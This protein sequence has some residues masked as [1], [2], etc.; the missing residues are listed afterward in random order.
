LIV[1][2]IS[3]VHS[4]LAALEAVLDDAGYWDAS[5]CAGDVV[6]YGPKPQECIDRIAFKGFNTVTGNHDRAV[7][8]VE[9][10]WFNDDAQEAIRI[11]R[12]MLSPANLKW[13]GSLPTGLSHE[14]DGVNVLVY[15]G[16][17]TRPLTSY[18]F[19]TEAETHA[20][21]YLRQTGADVLIL[22]HTH[23][24]YTVQRGNRFILNPG[25]V[26]Q[27]RDGDPRASYLI[28]DTESLKADHRRV[29][30]N[31]DATA[32]AIEAEGLPHR[33]AARLYSGM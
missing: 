2:V 33:F 5:I 22:G 4:N 28:L 19:Q 20:E 9:T 13:L 26:G 7:A 29:D 6:G 16:S 8:T 23:I 32:E 17:P 1:L 21:E 31:I 25:S 18:V 27:P 14:F 24:P 12:G 11:N 30:Y 15:H 10:D 3:D